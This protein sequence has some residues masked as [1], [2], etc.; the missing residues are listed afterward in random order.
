MGGFTLIATAFYF[1]FMSNNIIYIQ[2]AHLV[3]VIY[4]LLQVLYL[5]PESP[6]FNYSKDKFEAAKAN[7]EVVAYVN[8]VKNYNSQNFMFDTE[9]EKMDMAHA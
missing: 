9:K 2:V 7:L 5:F 4:M 8:G 6:R 3:F 1:Q